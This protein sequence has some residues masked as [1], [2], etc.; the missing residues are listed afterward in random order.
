[1]EARIASMVLELA[2]WIQAEVGIIGREG[3]LGA[4]LLR[5]AAAEAPAGQ[6]GAVDG[7][8]RSRVSRSRARGTTTTG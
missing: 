1:V 4:S 2:E 6:P 5:H 8:C 3:M 7:S